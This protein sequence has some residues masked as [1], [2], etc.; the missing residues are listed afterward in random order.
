M[1]LPYQGRVMQIALIAVGSVIG[2][3]IEAVWKVSSWL[4]LAIGAF[5]LVTP[6]LP[7]M[8]KHIG[9]GMILTSDFVTDLIKQ[10]VDYSME[11]FAERSV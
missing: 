9:L 6:R 5:L 11:F 8:F 7:R 4:T 10:G 3:V 2:N 1:R